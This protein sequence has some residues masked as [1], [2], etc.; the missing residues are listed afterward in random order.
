M[1]IVYVSDDGKE[2][3]RSKA[4]CV[5]YEKKIKKTVPVPVMFLK[6]AIRQC[7]PYMIAKKERDYLRDILERY[8]PKEEKK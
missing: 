2:V 4:D 6:E 3:F 8:L 5:A 1:K 7:T